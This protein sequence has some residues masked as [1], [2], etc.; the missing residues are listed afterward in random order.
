VPGIQYM[1]FCDPSGGTSD[2]FTL[3]IAHWEPPGKTRPGRAVLDLL[4]EERAPFDPKHVVNDHAAILRRYGIKDVEGDHY[5]GEWPSSRYLDA[6]VVDGDQIKPYRINY[7]PSEFTKVELYRNVLP[8]LNSRTVLL[9]DNVRMRTQ[10]TGLDRFVA[11]GGRDSIDHAPGARDDLC[12]S[13]AGVLCRVDRNRVMPKDP[14]LPP[15]QNLWD[16]LHKDI[17]D[18]MKEEKDGPEKRP[19]QW[20]RRRK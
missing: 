8:L 4:H 18:E 16:Q 7:W 6:K 12:N 19:N 17:A 15:P 2:S 1:A 11:R 9:L 5:A 13:A 20:R 10:F 14:G 3:A